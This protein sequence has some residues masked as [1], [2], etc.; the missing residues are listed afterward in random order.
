M[1]D[2]VVFGS[3]MID[4]IRYFTHK[5]K[6]IWVNNNMVKQSLCLLSYVDRMPKSG[7]TLHSTSFKTGYGGKGANQCIAAVRL[8]CKTAMIG[9]IGDDPYGAMY[10]RQFEAE[11]V[12]TQFL[13]KV[14]GEHSGVSLIMVSSDGQN[15]IVINANAN[16]FLSSEDCC[17]AKSLMDN[18][19][20]QQQRFSNQF[21]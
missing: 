6:V 12:D 13:E 15:Q 7:E 17:K 1:F 10:K 5:N 18:S 21:R 3:C 14:D 9:K 8:G 11:G 4:F 16:K 2:V 20:V 19:K